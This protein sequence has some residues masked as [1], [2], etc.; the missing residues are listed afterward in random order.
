MTASVRSLP[1]KG[2]VPLANLPRDQVRTYLAKLFE[3][4]H[5]RED[6][7][8]DQA[9]LVLLDLLKASDNLYELWLGLLTDQLLGFYEFDEKRMTL[10]GAGNDLTPMDEIT[11]AHEY[12]HALQDQHF[13]V[14]ATL[15]KLRRDSER[16]SA[17]QALTEGDATLAMSLY[18]R[19][20]LTADQLARIVR[21]PSATASA[22]KLAQVPVVLQVSLVFPYEQGLSFVTALAQSGGWRAVDRAYSNPPTTTEQI[23]HPEKYLTGEGA[24]EV[25]APDLAPVLGPGWSLWDDDALGEL[26]SLAYLIGNGIQ[27]DRAAR[28]AAGWGGDRLLLFR[29]ASGRHALVSL[30]AWDT[31]RDATEFFGAVRDLR[32][33]KGSVAPRGDGRL[34]WAAPGR[35]G[36]AAMSGSQVVLVISPDAEITKKVAERLASP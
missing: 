25:N 36:Y 16:S 27:A 26:G 1:V 17:M 12:V 21:D 35:A 3:K 32:A 11:L 28:A 13:G 33:A 30:S 15:D 10:V 4:D 22:A 34:E 18:A 2:A 7:E 9:S 19:Q 29:D 14:G 24:V 31:A 23:M 20:N 6:L 8:Q 5:A